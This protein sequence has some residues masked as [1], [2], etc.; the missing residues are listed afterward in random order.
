MLDATR[1]S[2]DFMALPLRDTPYLNARIVGRGNQGKM[3][4]PTAVLSRSMARR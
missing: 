3:R 1:L 4:W 2:D